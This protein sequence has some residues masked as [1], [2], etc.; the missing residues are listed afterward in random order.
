MPSL[1][2]YEGESVKMKQNKRKMTDCDI[3]LNAGR[4]VAKLSLSKIHQESL[5]S[6]MLIILLIF[7]SIFLTLYHRKF[8]CIF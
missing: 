1:R 7:F 6:A 4:I 2:L 3:R 8:F 5:H